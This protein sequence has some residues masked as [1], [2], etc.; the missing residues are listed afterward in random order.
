[1]QRENY[2]QLRILYPAKVLFYLR[3]KG[4]YIFKHKNLA[5]F[6]THGLLWKNF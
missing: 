5:V 6:A 1:M 4:F 2:F 3:V